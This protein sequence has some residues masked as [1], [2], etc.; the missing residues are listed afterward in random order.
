MSAEHG[1]LLILT[2]ATAAGKTE[3]KNSLQQLGIGRMISATTRSPRTNEI[4]GYDYHF[5]TRQEF[6]ENL[7]T[8]QFVETAK[9]N[10]HHYGTLK[11]ELD[12]LFAGENLVTLTEINGAAKYMQRVRKIYNPDEAEQLIGSIEIVFVGTEK[13]SILKDRFYDRQ[14]ISTK[15]RQDLR[16]RLRTDWEMWHRHK[17]QFNH[18]VINETDKLSDTVDLVLSLYA[19]THQLWGMDDYGNKRRMK[20]FPNEISALTAMKLYEDRGHKQTYWVDTI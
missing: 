1:K 2:G 4:P 3:I 8:H 15:A 20:T 6:K 9:Y 5:I 7:R 12:R 14:G 18:V 16:D 11:P 13:L 19:P 10:G 17:D